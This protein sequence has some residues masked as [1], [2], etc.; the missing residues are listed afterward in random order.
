MLAPT[1]HSVPTVQRPRA[2]TAPTAPAAGRGCVL[3]IDDDEAVLEVARAFLE[4]SGYRVL[5]AC[6]G[7]EGVSRFERSADEIDAV[8]LDVAM[9]DVGGEQAFLEMRRIRP[10]IP[11]A[12]ASGYGHDLAA[13]R[14]GAPGVAAFV[15]KPYEPEALAAALDAAIAWAVH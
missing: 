8:L 5:T 3:V 11:V 7:R 6:G 10:H 12:L 1:A 4:R 2:D 13:E 15:S 14:F 9:P